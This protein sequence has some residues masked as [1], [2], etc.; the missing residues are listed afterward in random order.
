MGESS[1]RRLGILFDV[2]SCGTTAFGGS[3]LLHDIQANDIHK[4]YFLQHVSRYWQGQYFIS[5]LLTNDI[6]QI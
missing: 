4:L 1:V 2:G 3:F 6:A 5:Q